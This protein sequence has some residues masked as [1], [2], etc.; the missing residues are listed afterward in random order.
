MHIEYKMKPKS[1]SCRGHP[2]PSKSFARCCPRHHSKGPPVR[3]IMARIPPLS[4]ATTWHL[5]V[6]FKWTYDQHQMR[7]SHISSYAIAYAK[8]LTN[9]NHW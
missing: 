1:K 5:T 9:I 6:G 2:P 4:L 3:V 7:L 8:L